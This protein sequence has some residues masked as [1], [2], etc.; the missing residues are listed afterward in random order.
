MSEEFPNPKKIGPYLIESYFRKGGISS[1]YL[2]RDPDS[3]EL[4]II[5][6]LQPQFR[7][8]QGV[9]SLF[10]KES[11]I[12]ELPEHPNIVKIFD[13]GSDSLGPYIAME[14]IRGT[15]LHTILKSA[16]LPLKRALN[17]LL[18]IC[19]A[20][21]YLHSFGIVHGDL[22]PENILITDLGQVKLIDFGISR[23]EDNRSTSSDVQAATPT[24]MSPEL[25]HEK[26]IPSVQSDI[27]S[28]GIL[29]F[30]LILGKITHGKVIISMA[31]KGLQAILARALRPNPSERYQNVVE[32]I[33]D[34]SRY[35]HSGEYQRER[36]GVDFFFELYDD[37]ETS[38]K[39]ILETSWL[40]F[41]EKEPHIGFSCASGVASVGLFAESSRSENGSLHT[42]FAQMK[43]SGVKGILDIYSFRS[44]WK[45]DPLHSSTD[46]Y[47]SVISSMI[48]DP[49]KNMWTLQKKDWGY[50][51]LIR[52]EKAV[53]VTSSCQIQPNDMLVYI[54]A[55]ISPILEF[56]HTPMPP[57]EQIV[58]TYCEQLS[59]LEPQ[60]FTDAFL[61]R[62]RVLGIAAFD[63]LPVCIFAYKHS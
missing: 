6:T 26:G 15:S 17:V 37:L 20:L 5:K 7:S 12:I 52:N 28:L 23:E 30:E 47:T 57:S 48:I 44:A 49:V 22:K 21:S 13:V 9:I 40:K 56:P 38:R 39:A 50:F 25:L 11:R 33:E 36:Q 46:Q 27:Y 31:P 3:H 63:T 53:Q 1:L 61:Q 59:N 29:A 41:L 51:F 4:L 43:N 42:I 18:Q 16:P 19:T 34:L 2:G 24:Y 8:N 10:K 58:G 32:L 55:S 14:F 62:L 35:V 60:Q 54:G 45:I